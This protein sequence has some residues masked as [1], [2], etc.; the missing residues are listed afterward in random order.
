MGD[1]TTEEDRHNSQEN[2]ENGVEEAKKRRQ[3]FFERIIEFAPSMIVG[4][5]LQGDIMFFNRTAEYITGYVNNEA[6]GKNFLSLLLQKKERK[7]ISAVLNKIVEGKGVNTIENLLIT[8]DG[9]ERLI[10]WSIGAAINNEN[11]IIG[12]ICIGNDI[13][14]RE[15][16]QEMEELRE[17]N[18]DFEDDTV[19]IDQ[20]GPISTTSSQEQGSETEGEW[21][22]VFNSIPE[23]IIIV[24]KENRILKINSAFA[25][26]MK[27]EPRELIGKKCCEIFHDENS[28][29]HSCV[30][31]KIIET[32]DSQTEEVY[33]PGS[34]TTTLISCSPYYNEN[35]ELQGSILIAKEITKSQGTQKTKESDK[36]IG[37]RTLVS[38]IQHEI[39]NPLG[40][41]LGNAEAIFEEENP[42]KIRI[43]SKEIIEAAKRLSEL[44]DSLARSIQKSSGPK[45]NSMDLNDFIKSSLADMKHDK[46]YEKVEVEYD[47]NPIPKIQCNP[48]EIL[49]VFINIIS[50]SM[51]NME[52]PGKIHICTRKVNGSVE[53]IFKD[54]G[55]GIP[56]EQLSR[57]FDP[58][59]AVENEDVRDEAVGMKTG[60]RMY[61]VS[62]ILKKYNAPINIESEVGK[63]TSYIIRFPHEGE[64]EQ[65]T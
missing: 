57:I 15:V 36:M 27:A 8:K 2:E 44:S 7:E 38:A 3:D 11:I 18:T 65:N 60:L 23:P 39:N 43:Y 25:K 5:D 13:T 4:I 32:E 64:T 42:I 17:L 45:L 12:S 33:D 56:K 37:I 58:L 46:K 16:I 41:V 59:F 53:M 35:G 52:G 19:T 49:E 51:E 29:I 62:S 10:S 22:N 54:D 55:A 1:N 31:K 21:E 47:L 40:G 50:N 48:A 28:P 63:G 9:E 24:S 30:H 14:D 20:V 34:G 6:L 61:V 26:E